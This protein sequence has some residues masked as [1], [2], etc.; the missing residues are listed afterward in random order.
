MTSM[1]LYGENAISGIETGFGLKYMILTAS[2][3]TCKRMALLA[4][5]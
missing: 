3:F 5:I 1:F 2:L 4:A